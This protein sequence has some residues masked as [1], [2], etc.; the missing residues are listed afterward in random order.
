MDFY[1]NNMGGARLIIHRLDLLKNET[2]DGEILE[3]IRV[4]KWAATGIL[5]RNKKA[6]AAAR[7]AAK[8]A[9]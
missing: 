8:E 9:G 2:D 6:L 4:M 7:K 5:G 1:E 3:M